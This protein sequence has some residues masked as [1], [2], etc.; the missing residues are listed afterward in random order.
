LAGC[1]RCSRK[2]PRTTDPR[3]RGRWR[4]TGTPVAPRPAVHGAAAPT[5]VVPGAV[6]P[7]PVVPGAGPEAVPTPT[8][9]VGRATALR[10]PAPGRAEPAAGAG[11][12][13]RA[14]GPAE[15]AGWATSGWT[16]PTGGVATAKV[17][18]RYPSRPLGGPR[19]AEGVGRAACGGRVGA[20]GLA[21]ALLVPPLLGLG[22]SA[23]GARAA[24]GVA[25]VG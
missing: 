21:A 14:R 11:R 12:R 16:Q 17:Q 10:M 8:P 25:L 7:A 2:R 1:S 9:A 22:W 5:P 23:P 13:G 15:A 3:R 19:A 6:A 4:G 20:V 18:R 24:R